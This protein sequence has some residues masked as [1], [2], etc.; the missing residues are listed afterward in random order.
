MMTRA[1]QGNPFQA[2]LL[3]LASSQSKAGRKTRSS[4]ARSVR[5]WL[6]SARFDNEP[7]QANILT[8]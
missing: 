1:Y 8:R 2:T 7:S 4:L 5:G 6:D 3:T